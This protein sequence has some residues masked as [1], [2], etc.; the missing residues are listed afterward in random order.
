ML[1]KEAVS[2]RLESDAGISYT[3]FS[4]QILQALD[5]LELYRRYGCTLQTGGSDQWGNLTAG[6]DLIR[7]VEG[8]ARARARTP[9]ITKADGTKFGKTEGGTVWLD[10][11]LTSPYAFYQF[12]LN[13]DDRDVAGYLRIFSFRPRE[14]IEALEA[15]HRRAAGG[16]R[17]P[18]RAGRGADHAGPRRG[19]RR[20]AVAAAA[21]ALFGQ[22]DARRARRG[23]AGRR[24]ARDAAR[25][26]RRRRRHRRR[27]ARRDRP[28]RRA[29]R[30]RPPGR[31]GGRRLR[32][33]RPR[34]RRG[35]GRR[36]PATACT[37]AGWCCAAASASVAGVESASADGRRAR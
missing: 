7:R 19:R 10:P 9:L 32:Q 18:A 16:P 29:S 26:G 4:Y 13:A 2:A 28:G 35:R 31:R 33:Q 21:Q 27:P 25:R 8:V 11:E 17:G 22:G 20:A 24:A 30:A 5:F 3:E 12:W 1:A 34:D 36:R 15:R 14:E 37:A 23:H 6:L